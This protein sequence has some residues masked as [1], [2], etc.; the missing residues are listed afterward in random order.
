MKCPYCGYDAK[1]PRCD[2]C[3]AA[4]EQKPVPKPEKV[5]ESA[6]VKP[7]KKEEK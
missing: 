2:H 7:K 3:Y 1:P 5:K 6:K 4:I